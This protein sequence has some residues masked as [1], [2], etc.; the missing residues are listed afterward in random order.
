MHCTFYQVP[1]LYQEASNTINLETLNVTGDLVV[2]ITRLLFVLVDYTS[3]EDSWWMCRI[4]K[5]W[6][7]IV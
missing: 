4:F 7:K 5:W 2:H 6:S 3:V 1:Q